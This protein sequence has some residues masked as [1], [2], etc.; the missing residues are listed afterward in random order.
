MTLAVL[1]ALLAAAAVGLLLWSLFLFLASLLNSTLAALITG[2]ASLAG[3][4]MLA[5]FARMMAR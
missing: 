4:G 3:A 2:L 1:A 5:W